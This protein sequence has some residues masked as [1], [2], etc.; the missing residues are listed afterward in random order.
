MQKFEENISDKAA[1]YCE[2]LAVVNTTTT[3]L[4]CSKLVGLWAWTKHGTPPV[5]SDVFI[6]CTI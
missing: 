1:S 2:T 6:R 4:K 3:F 5:R